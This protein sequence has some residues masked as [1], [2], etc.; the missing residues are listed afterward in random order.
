MITAKDFFINYKKLPINPIQQ[1]QNLFVADTRPVF[2]SKAAES[3]PPNQKK[4]GLAQGFLCNDHPQT[5]YKDFQGNLINTE[6][7]KLFQMASVKEAKRLFYEQDVKDPNSDMYLSPKDPIALKLE[8]LVRKVLFG[9]STNSVIDKPSISTL[10]TTTTNTHLSVL[11]GTET[12]GSSRVATVP[13]PG[14]APTLKETIILLHS[15][16]P[17]I[18]TV[19][20]GTN[21][22]GGYADILK[23]S[24][25]NI[26]KYTQSTSDNRFNLESLKETVNH[27]EDPRKAILLIQAD[28][29]NYIGVNPSSE[30]WKDLVEF[31]QEKEILPLVDNAYHGLMRGLT[32]DVEIV[33][34][35]AQTD[36]PFIVIDS[37]SK[38]AALYGKRVSFLHVVT[39][40]AEQAEIVRANLYGQIRT[41]FIGIPPFFKIIYYLLSN[42]E[43]YKFWLEKDL[44][45]ARS[46]LTETKDQMASLMGTNFAYLG[47]GITRGMFNK[48]NISYEGN[49]VLAEKYGIFIV[50]AKD[51]DRMIKTAENPNGSPAE[52]Q[53]INM[54]AIPVDSR[55]YVANAFKEV[56]TKYRT[57]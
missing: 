8:P 21:G 14:M 33:R 50:N 44:P 26:I 9:C 28:A 27:L 52:S 31:I 22:Y 57:D 20:L 4:Y 38:K 47:T 15:G 1:A 55:E 17:E 37:Y 51:E 49:K 32:E 30:Q 24:F 6:T 25:K 42:P 46:I 10:T 43:T 2:G 11:I 56:Y 16:H 39:G 12:I 40:S 13:L 29:Y 45:A 35:L 7:G 5:D 53:R 34:L 3:L 19:V 18:D 23:G 41:S 54:A 48:I 36:L